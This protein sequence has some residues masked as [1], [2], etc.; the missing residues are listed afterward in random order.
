VHVHL[1][2]PAP[3]QGEDLLD[4]VARQWLDRAGS[5]DQLVEVLAPGGGADRGADLRGA[6]GEA[7]AELGPTVD[8]GPLED[9]C[10]QRGAVPQVGP[11]RG[12][13]HVAEGV[14]GR[15]GHRPHRDDARVPV[16]QLVPK[17]VGGEPLKWVQV[18]DVAVDQPV[19]VSGAQRRE[20]GG[21][22]PREDLEHEATHET[23]VLDALQI[24]EHVP[25]R[26]QP[27]PEPVHRAQLADG[28]RPDAP[29]L[30]VRSDRGAHVGRGAP[31]Q[32]DDHRRNRAGALG[33][34]VAEHLQRVAVLA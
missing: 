15:T 10:D 7:D 13:G 6:E 4:D 30:D 24:T 5:P 32:L 27:V 25:A 1:I 11:P 19:E 2:R 22:G 17:L 31:A 26:C 16:E 14:D 34:G 21:G 18:G 23:V 28:H 8:A 20:R 29:R 3:L 9:R 33:E 12:A